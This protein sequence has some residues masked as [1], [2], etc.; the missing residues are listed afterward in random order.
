[1]FDGCEPIIASSADK[2]SDDVRLVTMI[3]KRFCP[4]FS[5]DSAFLFLFIDQPMEISSRHAV[6]RQTLLKLSR[7]SKSLWLFSQR[8][9]FFADASKTIWPTCIASELRNRFRFVATEACLLRRNRAR[10]YTVPFFSGLVSQVV[11]MLTYPSY[12]EPVPGVGMKVGKWL[13]NQAARANFH[14]AIVS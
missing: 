7:R 10:T 3:D 13:I 14:G 9:A 1:M 8:P 11:T 12:A 2:P 5:A 4:R 6:V